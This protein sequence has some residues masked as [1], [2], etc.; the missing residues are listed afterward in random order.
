MQFVFSEKCLEYES[1]GHPES[2]S[3]VRAI[4]DLLKSKGVEFIEPSPCT[5]EDILSVH[6]H[7]L[8]D[9]VKNGSYS[10]PDTPVLPGIYDHARLSVGAAL[11]ASR[12][13]GFSIVRPPGHH[14]QKAHLG[15]FCYF[16]NTAIAVK[17]LGKK[18]A[19]LDIDCHHGNGTEDIF[20]GNQEV[21]YVSL[22]RY[23]FFYPGT[24]GESK[25]NIRNFP[26]QY[27]ISESQYIEALRQAIDEINEFAPLFLGVSIGF[28]TY[29]LDPVGGLGLEI[30]SYRRIG[31]LIREIDTPTFYVL[32][33]GYSP[34]IGECL[35]QLVGM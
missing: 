30:E 23:G 33:G 10:D 16:N 3:R 21:L 29:K 34:D 6:T 24:G 26:L 32:E 7:D 18:A 2:P 1:P 27:G 14:A 22:H 8:L 5:E 15:G 19:I 31:E 35:W 17:R 28:D 9:M 4:Y 13:S 12:V 25:G 20:A 11:L